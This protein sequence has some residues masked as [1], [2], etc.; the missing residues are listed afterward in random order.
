MAM[1]VAPGVVGGLLW[2]QL[3]PNQLGLMMFGKGWNWLVDDGTE[4]IHDAVAIKNDPDGAF[5][6]RQMKQSEVE[7][8][9]GKEAS[10]DARLLGL[11]F[12]GLNREERQWRDV[13]KEVG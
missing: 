10:A 2:W 4:V 1:A 11:A 5:L 8:F 12:Q 6:L 7:K 9:K 13:S 3:C